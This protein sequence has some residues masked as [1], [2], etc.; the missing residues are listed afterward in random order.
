MP[1]AR[2]ERERAGGGQRARRPPR[3][4]R[5]S[6]SSAA[7]PRGDRLERP[8]GDGRLG[9]RAHAGT[10]SGLPAGTGPSSGPGSRPRSRAA[11]TSGAISATVSAQ[12]SRSAPGPSAVVGQHDRAGLESGPRPPRASRRRRRRAS[13]AC[14]RSSRR[15]AGRARAASSGVNGARSPHGV[16]QRRGRTPSRR[17]AA[18]AALEVVGDPLGRVRAGWRR[19]SWPC[20][21]TSWPSASV[22]P[23]QRPDARAAALAEDEERRPRA[24]ARERVEHRGGP[25]RVGPV[26][27]G[28]R[29]GHPSGLPGSCRREPPPGSGA[30][31]CSGGRR[32][33][34]DAAW[35]GEGNANR[36]HGRHRQRRHQR[37]AR[38]SAPTTASRRS[39]GSP[40]DG[41]AGGRPRTRWVTADVASDALA[42]AV[43]RRRRRDPLAWLIQPAA[44]RAQLRARQ[45][46]RLAAG[47][48]GGGRGR[49]ACARARVVGRRLLARARRTVAVDESWPTRRGAD[50]VLL[51]PQGGG[52]TR[53]GRAW[54]RPTELRVVR[55]R[56]GLIFK[57]EA[58]SEI[59][60]LFAGPLLPSRCSG[61]ALLPVLPLPDGLVLQAVHGDD[62]GRGLP[63]GACPRTRARGVQRRGRAGA[64]PGDARPRARRAPRRAAGAPVRAARRPHLARAPSADPARLAG[65]GARRA[66][67]GHRRARAELGWRPRHTAEQ[68]LHELLE[69]MREPAGLDTPPLEP[70]AGG[71]LRVREFLTG[72]GGRL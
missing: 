52:R 31:S 19:C 16:R 62:V 32:F 48:R 39:S 57:R 64:R 37:R 53:A 65:H 46:R 6:A 13:R 20:S 1:V 12:P 23:H 21:S 71:A 27:E 67:H 58:G 29:P 5:G 36:R 51:A 11:A 3:G 49:R 63:A 40:A 22:A 72:L 45:R 8:G 55:L 25:A 41:R 43:R 54:R 38:R 50:V 35:E 30:A 14:R 66:G 33:T 44:T 2:R 70:R 26:V 18:S 69:G 68:A 61:P 24:R 28:Q 15:A 42:A 17:S 7:A 60:R 4:R 10:S 59:R 9:Q 34:G 56:P 47:V